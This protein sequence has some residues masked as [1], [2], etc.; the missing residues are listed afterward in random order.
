MKRYTFLIACIVTFASTFTYAQDDKKAQKAL[1]KEWKKKL[2]A[3]SPM[4]YKALVEE[5][6]ELAESKS[7]LQSENSDLQGKVSNLETQVVKLESEIDDYKAAAAAAE[8]AAQQQGSS[9]SYDSY[10]KPDMA[11]VKFKVQ[12][13]AFRSFDIRKYF[14]NHKNFSGEVDPDGTMKYTLGIFKEYWEADKFKKYL[15]DMGV[16]GA[17]VVAYKDGQRVNIKDALEGVL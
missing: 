1:E 14:D 2:K 15:R 13:G 7:Q 17:W 11:G 8:E 12:V 6:N 4:D 5:K 9:D 16:K 3:L 10:S